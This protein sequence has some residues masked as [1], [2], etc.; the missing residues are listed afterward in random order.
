MTLSELKETA[1]IHQ[2]AYFLADEIREID[3]FEHECLI[4][5]EIIKKVFFGAKYFAECLIKNKYEKVFVIPLYD[6]LGAGGL[7]LIENSNN[8][9]IM[10]EYR[11]KN[12]D[13]LVSMI[14]WHY[15]K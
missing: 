2:M 10:P 3:Y 5:D 8:P 9:E 11:L 15:G 7:D 1:I 13:A 14:K 12:I 4:Y 6:L